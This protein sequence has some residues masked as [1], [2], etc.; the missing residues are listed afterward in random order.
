[1]W[2][3]WEGADPNYIIQLLELS[4][5]NTKDSCSVCSLLLIEVAQEV[6]Q[7]YG[8]DRFC[9][10]GAGDYMLLDTLHA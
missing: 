4:K 6:Y 9:P 8:D 10:T 1:M 5:K 3:S 2:Q 7:L